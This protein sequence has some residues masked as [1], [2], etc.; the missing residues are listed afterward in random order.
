MWETYVVVAPILRVAVKRVPCIC[1]HG[2]KQ[3]ATTS[4]Y[5]RAMGNS[6]S[7]PAPPSKDARPEEPK[8]QRAALRT[9]KKSLELPDLVSLD[10]SPAS[11][12]RGRHPTPPKSACIPIPQANNH[13]VNKGEPRPRPQNNFSAT[14]MLV[15]EPSTHIPFPPPTRGTA[16]APLAAAAAQNQYFRSIQPSRG[17]HPTS[18]QRHHQK[19]A[20][21]RLQELYSQ[22]NQVPAPPP[23]SLDSDS[24]DPSSFF[25]PEVVHSSIPIGLLKGVTTDDGASPKVSTDDSEPIHVKITWRGGGKS[26]LLA[27]AGDNDWKGRQVMER[28]YV[29]PLA[30]FR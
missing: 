1:R 10:L 30:Y 19:M 7:S 12:Y 26:V 3:E 6:T 20:Q 21:P 15:A 4:S 27:R 17:H 9:K 13:A 11:P 16:N 23:S 8:P 22:S 2:A 24:L 14:D 25:V 29:R 5:R 28:E 18:T